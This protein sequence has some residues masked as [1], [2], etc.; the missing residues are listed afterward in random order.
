MYDALGVPFEPEI[1]DWPAIEDRCKRKRRDVDEVDDSAPQHKTVHDGIGSIRE[2][3]K[4]SED[5]RRSY[6]ASRHAVEDGIQPV[7]LLH[8]AVSMRLARG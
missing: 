3:A 7:N 4:I 6:Q 5:Y 1:V 8:G 2:Y